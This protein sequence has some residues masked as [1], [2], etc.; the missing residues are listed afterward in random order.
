MNAHLPLSLAAS[1]VIAEVLLSASFMLRA[2]DDRDLVPDPEIITSSALVA[3]LLLTP[4]KTTPISPGHPTPATYF[5]KPEED[6][7][8]R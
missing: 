7:R 2:S 6:D 3:P 8:R 4:A 5:R 1:Q